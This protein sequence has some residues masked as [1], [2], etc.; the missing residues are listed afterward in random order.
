[1][2]GDI[3]LTFCSPFALNPICLSVLSRFFHTAQL[4]ERQRSPRPRSRERPLEQTGGIDFCDRDGV[5]NEG[6]IWFDHV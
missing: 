4:Q 2:V 5:D 3:S 6:L 1:M